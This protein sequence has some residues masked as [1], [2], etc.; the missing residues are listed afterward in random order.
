MFESYLFASAYY[1]Y[2]THFASPLSSASVI[3]WM[4]P[5]GLARPAPRSDLLVLSTT[6]RYITV[7]HINQGISVMTEPGKSKRKKQV[8]K[9]REL[10]IMGT[11]RI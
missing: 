11:A 2:R 5:R 3:D 4:V 7:V 8:P 9:T 1:P 6:I 10:A